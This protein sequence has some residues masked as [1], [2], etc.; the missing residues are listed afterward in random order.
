MEKKKNLSMFLTSV[1]CLI[2]CVISIIF[3]NKLP[4]KVATHF[5]FNGIPD[6]YSSKI[7]AAF[8]I[9]IFM[10][11][12]NIITNLVL[13]KNTIRGKGGRIIASIAR[14]TIPA[15]AVLIQSF[16]VIY[17]CGIDF[18]I[19]N[20]IMLMVG[21]MIMVIGNYLPKCEQNNLVGI[22]T[23]WALKDRDNWKKTHRFSGYLWIILGFVLCINT[24]IRID[25]INIIVIIMMLVIPMTYSYGIY[26]GCK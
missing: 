4:D 18:N 8:G 5:D 13:D 22:K 7:V 1:I 16:I 24:F 12:I 11:V 6:G 14:W 19:S 9:P 26:K 21:L 2:P 23:P 3:Y 10:L 17:S 25:F 15:M 20:C